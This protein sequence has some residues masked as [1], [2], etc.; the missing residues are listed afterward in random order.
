M[1]AR[2][3]V[4]TVTAAE[5]LAQLTEELRA[6]VAELRVYAGKQPEDDLYQGIQMCA[7]DIA[8]E[9]ETR[10]LSGKEEAR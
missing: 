9:I 8:D 6:Y 4:R 2:G 1:S 3:A 5:R 10:F 7:Q